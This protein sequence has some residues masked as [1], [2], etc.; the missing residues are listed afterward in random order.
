MK[1]IKLEELRGAEDVNTLKVEEYRRDA[2]PVAVIILT[3]IGVVVASRRVR[4]GSGT[5]IALGIVAATIFVLMD[6]FSA[7]FSSKGDLPPYI[8]AWIPDFVFL[9]VAYYLYRKAPK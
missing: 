4:G 9:F 3:F 1:F 6:R 2:T 7:I 8:A 5:H